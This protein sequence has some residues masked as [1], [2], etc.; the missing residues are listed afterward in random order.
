MNIAF[1]TCYLKTPLFLAISKMLCRER[2][3]INVFWVS[4]SRKWTKY[5]TENGV[6]PDSICQVNAKSRI[7]GHDRKEAEILISKAEQKNNV[8]SNFIISS[9]RVVSEWKVQESRE[10]LLY[11]TKMLSDFY[12]EKDI[13]FIFGEATALHEVLS[14]FLAKTLGILFLKPHTVRIPNARFAFFEGYLE[15]CVVKRNRE[16]TSQDEN[17]IKEELSKVINKS[18][19]PS[20]FYKNN[21]R[22]GF[23]SPNV[24]KK[25]VMKLPE[26]VIEPK[27]NASSKTLSYHLIKENKLAV[28][29][30]IALLKAS[31]PFVKP[32]KKE[33]YVLFTL[34]KQPEASID[35]LAQKCSN[36]VEIIRQLSLSVPSN[37]KIYVKEHS[38]A[39]GE[40]AL[41][42]YNKI[43]KIPGVKLIDPYEDS[44]KL[45]K[46][47]ELVL[48]VSGTIA[49]EALLFG[50]PSITLSPM[51]F[52]NG[53]G[54]VFSS[55]DP[56]ILTQKILDIEEVSDGEAIEVVKE[57]YI[58]S[59]PGS[60]D[61]VVNDPDC[62]S[63]INVQNVTKAF[64]GVM[65]NERR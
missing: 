20:Y 29:L 54:C 18:Q 37:T 38:N 63:E 15:Q 39:M 35:V 52:N 59:Y 9:D 8:S 41:G 58:N 57:V 16:L 56:D 31:S 60:V 25:A 14:A 53:R 43:R 55:H 3:D 24:W 26:A 42:F 28:P 32:C 21:K 46:N 47:A 44:H 22:H 34:H 33:K 27:Y 62:L 4:S 50:V 5:L 51:F 30:K 11:S 7:E 10:Y 64:L 6:L 48:T 17:K 65:E 40:R 1:I 13:K 61:D 45:V 2:D 12:R 36:Q 49:Y 19:K 23:F